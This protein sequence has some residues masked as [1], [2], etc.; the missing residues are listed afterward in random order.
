MA[1]LY[2]INAAMD[3][4]ELLE[5]NKYERFRRLRDCEIAK[6]EILVD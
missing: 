4:T 5:R 6:S 1:A 2:Q 3:I